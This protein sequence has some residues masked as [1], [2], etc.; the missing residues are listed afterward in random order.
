MASSCCRAPENCHA[1][2]CHYRAWRIYQPQ[3]QL[4]PSSLALLGADRKM[5]LIVKLPWKTKAITVP[6]NYFSSQ[7]NISSARNTCRITTDE[8]LF[9]LPHYLLSPHMKQ[10]LSLYQCHGTSTK[11]VLSTF[12]PRAEQRLVLHCSSCCTPLDTTTRID[13]PN[14]T[15]HQFPRVKWLRL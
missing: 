5:F 12:S 8:K 11:I 6:F 4:T 15:Y 2:C 9:P 7:G 10:I 13:S 14:S 3:T 1:Y